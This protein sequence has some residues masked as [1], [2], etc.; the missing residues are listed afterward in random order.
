MLKVGSRVKLI[1]DYQGRAL[2]TLRSYVISEIG[3]HSPE[4]TSYV[5][6]LAGNPHPWLSHIFEPAP[7]SFGEDDDELPWHLNYGRPY[8]AAVAA[9]AARARS[10]G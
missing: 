10:E 7:E 1:E 5:V 6:Y 4:D 8:D 3:A 9:F 2:N